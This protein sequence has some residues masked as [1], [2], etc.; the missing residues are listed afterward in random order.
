MRYTSDKHLNAVLTATIREHGCT[1][2]T[3]GGGHLKLQFPTGQFV[4]VASTTGCRGGVRNV[5]ARIKRTIRESA[6]QQQSK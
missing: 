4:F 6:Q 5:E 1:V 2:I 3:T